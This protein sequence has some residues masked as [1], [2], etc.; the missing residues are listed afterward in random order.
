MSEAPQVSWQTR[1]HYALAEIVTKSDTLQASRQTLLLH[2][3]AEAVINCEALQASRR[4]RREMAA[5]DKR[6]KEEDSAVHLGKTA[7]GARPPGLAG[8]ESRPHPTRLGRS[9]APSQPQTARSSTG[10]L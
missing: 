8:G 6:G 7:A 10:S 4:S 5:S 3:L 9:L 1:L 2:A